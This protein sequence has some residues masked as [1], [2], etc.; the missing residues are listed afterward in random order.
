[1]IV[2]DSL[3]DTPLREAMQIGKAPAMEFLSRHGMYFPQVVS[4]FPTMSV[5]ID[6]TLLTGTHPNEHRI[7]GLTYY[8]PEERRV[9]NFGTGLR[10]SLAFGLRSV[11]RDGLQHLNQ[12]FL[13]KNV[14]TIHEEY[15]GPTGSIGAMIFRGHRQ[16][17]LKLPLLPVLFGLVPRSVKAG[18]PEIFSLGSLHRLFPD[19]RPAGPFTRYGLNDKF[20]RMELVSLMRSGQLPPFTIVYFPKN[21]DAVHQKGPSWIEGIEMVDREL[22]EIL[23]AFPSWEEAIEQVTFIVV[24]DSGQAKVIPDR[25]EAYVDLRKRLKGWKIMPVRRKR[26]RAQDQIVLCVNERMAYLYPVA[27]SPTSVEIARALKQENKL[28]VIAWKEDGWIHVYSGQREGKLQFRPGDRFTDEYGQT[29]D[30][31]GDLPILD[32]TVEEGNRIVCGVYPDVLARLHGVMDT[33]EQVVVVTVSPGYEMV[34][35]K[36]PKHP[37]AAHGSLHQLDSLVPMIV[38]GTDRLPPSLRLIDFKRWILELLSE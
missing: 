4:S 3:M 11:L 36:S 2:V 30:L 35:E 23:H 17:R 7:F 22:Q 27:D 1:M 28:D 33:A 12:R 37:G 14:R 34:G 32:L 9:I 25:K 16:V 8:H 38:C 21:D 20:S 29:W 19:S 24:G 13:S 31:I 5:C 26:P 15:H 18:T 10:E 6:S